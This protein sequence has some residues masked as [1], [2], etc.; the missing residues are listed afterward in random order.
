MV[1]AQQ[2]THIADAEPA[3]LQR[4]T[5]AGGFIGSGTEEHDFTIARDLAVTTLQ[6]LRRNAQGAG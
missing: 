6:F 2:G 5:G 4:R 3:K 1:S